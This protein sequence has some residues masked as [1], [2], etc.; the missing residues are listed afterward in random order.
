MER[1]AVALLVASAAL[2]AQGAVQGRVVSAV[3]GS[4]V[5]R[6]VVTLKGEETYLVRTDGEGRFALRDVTPGKYEVEARDGYQG[7]AS[8]AV[9]VAAGANAA[10]RVQLVPLATIAGRIVDEQGDPVAEASVE[11][12]HYRF[13]GSNKQLRANA[14]ATTNDRGE[15]LVAD[16]APSR[17]YVRASM[18]DQ[19]P[20][21]I[22]GIADRGPRRQLVYAAAY[23]PGTRDVTRA[24]MLDAT[25]GAEVRNVDL[26][27][28]RQGVYSISG[29]APPGQQVELIRLGGEPRGAY[30]TNRGSSG[31]F[32]IWGL[33]PGP[34]AV[35]AKKQGVLWAMKRVEI[36]EDDVRGVD[37]TSEN[38]VAVA[39]RVVGAPAGARVVLASE[40]A[41][42]LDL[43]A[44][45]EGD[46]SFR[47]N[48]PAERYVV[49]VQG[50]GAYVQSMKIG[51]RVVAD[52]RVTPGAAAG[53]VVI[54]V[55]TAMG[56]VEGTV[57]D[58]G[59]RPAVGVNVTLVPDQ[60]LPYWG[61]M[62]RT[63]VTNGSGSFTMAGVIPAEYRL[64]APSGAEPGA[65]LDA[66][67]RKPFDSEGT[68]VRVE[69]D[70]TV[71]VKLAAI[72][73][74]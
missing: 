4:V 17:Y 15:Y 44:P 9:M 21:I 25:P 34:Y 28:E 69:A 50:G 71:N 70:G 54:A 49:R 53:E 31:P 14:R 24:A 65:P 23:Y 56:R 26:R 66:E 10:L 1:A 61:E 8:P 59:G 41:A 67:F 72:E 38:A 29:S 58:A 22:G 39:G 64:F 2:H 30:A 11:A 19:D 18:P 35:T 12:M 32:E 62:A 63:A 43:T 33:T 40:E 52:H 57:V 45:V 73:L 51:D 5:K 48:A 27:L 16:V 74:R 36:G 6:A 42:A 68:A 46:G 60:R 55:S 37:L 13:T 20:P 3:D 47:V 7:K